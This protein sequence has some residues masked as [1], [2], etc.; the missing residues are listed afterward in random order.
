MC[1]APLSRSHSGSPRGAHTLFS[2]NVLAPTALPQVHAKL[3]PLGPL[4]TVS[5][6]LSRIRLVVILS[7][8]APSVTE[9]A[10]SPKRPLSARAAEVIPRERDANRIVLPLI[11]GLH[12][13]PEQWHS[14]RAISSPLSSAFAARSLAG[15]GARANRA[16]LIETLSRII[17]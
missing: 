7:A 1:S 13:R 6:T 10:L 8:A 5:P 2:A 12:S 3:S 11:D 4:R 16:I 14:K 17:Y 9:S 15:N